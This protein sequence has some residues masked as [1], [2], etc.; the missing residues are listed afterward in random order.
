[1]QSSG[2]AGERAPDNATAA[3]NLGTALEDLNRATDAVAA[4]R[5]ALSNDPDF[6]DAHYN[7]GQLYERLQDRTAA[8]RHLTR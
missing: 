6:A 7:L 8:L 3:F 4:Y 2:A 5:Q 1:M